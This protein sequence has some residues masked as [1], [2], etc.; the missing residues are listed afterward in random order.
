[1]NDLF[2]A[3]Y[4]G[5]SPLNL[6]YIENFSS[7]IYETGAYVTMGWLMI[8]ISIVMTVLY[9]F[10]FSNYSVFYK[11]IYWFLYLVLIAI[12]NFAVAYNI[13][14]S[15]I[16]DLYISSEQ[17]NYYGINDYFQLSIVNALY[18]FIL[19]FIVSLLVKS[20]SVQATKTPF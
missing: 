7:D 15:A 16:E 1:M 2:A 13:S 20:F 11:K 14:L 5:F 19:C 18:G 6:F 8:I 3:L 12:V 17:G 9:Y 4:E 10:L